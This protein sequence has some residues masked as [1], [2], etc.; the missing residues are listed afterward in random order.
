MKCVYCGHAIQ[1]ELQPVTV[2]EDNL[3]RM[4]CIDGTACTERKGK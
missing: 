1:S 2:W 3:L 4:I